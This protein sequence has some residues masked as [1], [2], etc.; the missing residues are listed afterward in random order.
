MPPWKPEPGSGDFAGERRLS[1]AQIRT[2]AQW[3]A[4][5]HVSRATRS[6]LPPPPRSNAGWQL[7]APDLVVTLPEYTLRADGVDVFRNFV[8]TVPGA[9][10]ALRAR[11]RIPSRRSRRAPREHPRRPDAGVAASGRSRPRA[12]VRRHDSPFGR[13][14]RRPFP[15]LDAGTGVA[16]RART[17]S[18][19]ASTPANDFVVQLHLQPTGKPERVRPSIGL[20]LRERAADARRRPFCGSGARTS[21][22]PPARATTASPTRTSCRWTPRSAPFSRTRTIARAASPHGRRFRMARAVR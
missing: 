15:R 13:L 9:G 8:V 4:E 5:R 1:D 17:T 21:T 19:G 18:R 6:D 2:I 3:A 22:S 20:V 11:H 12:G 7:G 10:T 14:S 16:A